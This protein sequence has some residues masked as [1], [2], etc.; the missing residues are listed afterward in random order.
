M[1]NKR[2][3]EVLR[4]LRENSNQSVKDF[5]GG[6]ISEHYG[7]R[8]ETCRQQLSQVIFQ[9]I[10][11]KHSVT[12]SEF[13]FIKNS[14][15]LKES[16]YVV[17]DFV[18][19]ML[20]SNVKELRLF[21]KN[22][23][24]ES[25]PEQSYYKYF[26]EIALTRSRYLH[27]NQLEKMRKSMETI[28]N[29]LLKKEQWTYIELVVVSNLICVF[30]S[31]Y[32][33]SI[34]NRIFK[35]LNKYAS[36]QESAKVRILAFRNYCEVLFLDH[37]Y[38]KVR[39]F[40]KKILCEALKR[41]DGLLKCECEFQL[42]KLEWMQTWGQKKQISEKVSEILWVLKF[43]QQSSLERWMRNEWMQW[44]EQEIQHC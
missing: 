31:D 10:L 6:I 13:E 35:S 33:D 36:Y 17:R 5:Y 9:Q 2:T 19:V 37:S 32:R 38:Q 42:C 25:H 40:S 43:M 16:D 21:A 18:S 24:K 34:V 12:L 4:E 30:D 28:W 26:I 20:T 14:Y 3:G 44:V 11:D 8:V 22:L 23:A 7:Y 41:Q 1:E 15:Q 27:Q 29:D 39:N